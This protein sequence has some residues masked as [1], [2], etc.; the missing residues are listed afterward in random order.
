MV[1]SLFCGT[2]CSPG[3]RCITHLL[4]GLLG[5]VSPCRLERNLGVN[6]I[7]NTPLHLSLRIIKALGLPEDHRIHLLQVPH[8][9]YYTWQKKWKSLLG[10]FFSFFLFLYLRFRP[11]WKITEME[12]ILF[13]TCP[14]PSCVN[15]STNTIKS[16]QNMLRFVGTVARNLDILRDLHLDISW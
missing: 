4:P 1:V 7:R 14:V 12:R 8:R 10:E 6:S 2:L 13:F 5:T 16:S 9:N 3:S 15:F 11:H